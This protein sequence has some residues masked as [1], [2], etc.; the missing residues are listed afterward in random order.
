MDLKLKGKKAIITGSTK[1]I[2]KAIALSLASEGCQ[3]VVTGRDKEQVE[4]TAQE[5]KTASGTMAYP[6]QID[7]QKEGSAE[8]LLQIGREILGDIDILVN[9]A[10]IWPTSYV[11]DMQ[12]DEFEKTMYLN[13]EV[14]YI[15][16]RNA[17]NYFLENKK[18][19]KII[20]I[21]SQAAFHGSTTGHAHYA[22]SKAGLV[23]FM[24]SQ[25]R[26][27]AKYGININAVAPGMVDT[28]MVRDNV[29]KNEEYYK[30]RIPVGRLAKPEEIADIV[31]FLASER[32]DYLTGIT[33]DA[34]GGMLMR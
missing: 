4:K 28:D 7:L 13:L 5:I 19:G 11:T 27:V 14:P 9:N 2:G 6:I 1:G 25:A 34:T 23:A 22:A 29:L 20:H 15:L 26:E 12:K 8:Q 24:I 18:K 33:I 16:S 3:V 10:G 21:V 32:A 31:T 30:N 17:A